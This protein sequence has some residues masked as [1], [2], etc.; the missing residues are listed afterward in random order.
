MVKTELEQAELLTVLDDY[1]PDKQPISVLHQ[2]D[3]HMPAR[4]RKTYDYICQAL[5]EYQA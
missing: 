2:N 1:A 4:V 5:Q 3:P